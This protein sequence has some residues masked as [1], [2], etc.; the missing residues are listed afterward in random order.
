MH[1]RSINWRP[2][3]FESSGIIIPVNADS[4]LERVVSVG[5]EKRGWSLKSFQRIL[6]SH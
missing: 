2:E 6:T 1:Y 3:E 5:V 4:G